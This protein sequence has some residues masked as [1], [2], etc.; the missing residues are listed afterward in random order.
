MTVRGAVI[1]VLVSFFSFFLFFPF[2]FFKQKSH[3]F[4]IVQSRYQAILSYLTS[5]K[6]YAL[7]SQVD[8]QCYM[9]VENIWQVVTYSTALV[10]LV[11]EWVGE[12]D[13]VWLAVVS[14]DFTP[15]L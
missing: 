7:S 2:F 5:L 11:G 1:L 8:N 14:S 4:S 15:D 12:L 9:Y 6:G 13:C 10:K 3:H